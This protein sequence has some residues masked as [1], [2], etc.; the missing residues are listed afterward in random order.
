M[1]HNVEARGYFDVP[2]LRWAGAKWKLAKWIIAQFP[3][4]ISYV[5]PFTGSAAIF[6]RKS[7]SKIEVLNDLN[8]DVLNFFDVLRSRPDELIRAIQLTPFSRAEYER[9]YE[10]TEDP[11]ERARR[12]YV[13]CWQSFGAYAGKKT[14]WRHQPTE[15]RGTGIAREFSRVNGLWHA[16]ERLKMAQLECRPALEVVERFDTPDTLFYVDPPYPWKDRAEGGR[17]RYQHEMT[18]A[19]H[20]ALAGAIHQ[21]KGMF[22]ISGY[23]GLYSDLFADWRVVSKST[24]TNGNSVAT[25]YLW[26]SPSVDDA[27][28]KANITRIQAEFWRA[29]GQHAHRQLQTPRLF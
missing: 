10:P 19:D 23:E 29:L 15:L 8:Q 26:I 9:S 13:L 5:E 1:T 18:N 6:L 21:A 14:G 11:L 27:I 24:T 28:Q 12:L 25:E 22:L 20:A 17:H 2:L 4:H 3:P 7:P 16:V